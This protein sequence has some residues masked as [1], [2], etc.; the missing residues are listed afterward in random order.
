MPWFAH[1]A[2]KGGKNTLKVCD[3]VGES[4]AWFFGITSPRYQLEYD[5]YHRIQ[6]EAKRKQELAKGWGDG[7]DE[8]EVMTKQPEQTESVELSKVT[9]RSE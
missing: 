4:L 3:N 1:K 7:T 2:Y 6:A 5:E 9:T 8:N